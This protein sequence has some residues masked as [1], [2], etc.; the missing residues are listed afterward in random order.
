VESTYGLR[1]ADS[2]YE[3]VVIMETRKPE[4]F[5]NHLL[6]DCARRLKGT[7]ILDMNGGIMKRYFS[8]IGCLLLLTTAS[9]VVWAK[10]QPSIVFIGD[11]LSDTG[12]RFFDEGIVNT[13]P[14]DLA[15][16]DNLVPSYPYAIGGPTFTN[17][18]AWSERFARMLGDPGAAQAALRSNGIAS[19]YAYAGARASNEPPLEPNTNRNLTDQ[20]DQ[21]LADVNHQAYSDALH[22]VFIGGN[23]VAESVGAYLL[24][25][26]QDPAQAQFISE[27]IISNAVQSVFS[28]VIEVRQAGAQRFLL[29]LTPNAGYSPL[30][31]AARPFSPVVGATVA[32]GF[33]CAIAGEGVTRSCPASADPTLVQLLE[34]SG[35]EVDVVDVQEIVDEIMGNPTSYGLANT[36]DHCIAPDEPPYQ[37]RN[38]EQ[39]FYWDNI[40]PT[41][42]IHEIVASVAVSLVTH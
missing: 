32:S 40:H 36:S 19:N 22:V 9:G 10:A 5:G 15:A 25:V 27:W 17:G 42:R 38:P 6:F 34:A 41:A 28:N 33:N 29:M 16:A 1:N 35:A 39:Y 2:R 7:L 24:L 30:F 37:C 3:Y 8:L 11:S 21:Y 20:V 23:D 13:P 14:Y 31:A 4:T 12:N 18:M 26:Q